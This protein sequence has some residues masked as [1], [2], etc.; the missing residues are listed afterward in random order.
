MDALTATQVLSRIPYLLKFRGLATRLAT[1]RIVPVGLL[2]GQ[3]SCSA[4]R[5]VDATVL[6][7]WFTAVSLTLIAHDVASNDI[8]LKQ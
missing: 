6:M 4:K 1:P 5:V 2:N 8:G 7:V 3:S